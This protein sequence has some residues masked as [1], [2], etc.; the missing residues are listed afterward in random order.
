MACFQLMEG[1]GPTCLYCGWK[2]K[3]K[4]EFPSALPHGVILQQRYLIG[5]VLGQ[6]GFGITYAAYDLQHSTRVAIK[7]YFP[8]D[9]ARRNPNKDVETTSDG[10]Q[11]L[12]QYGLQRFQDEAGSLARFTRHPGMVAVYDFFH[13]HMTAYLVMQYVEGKTWMK[14]IEENGGRMGVDSALGILIPALDALQAVHEVGMLHR[15]ISPDNIMVLPNRQ[16]KLID[17]GA[18][19]YAMKQQNQEF[20]I[21]FKPGFTPEEQY[22]TRGNRGPWSDIYSISATFYKAI[23]GKIPRDAMNR[24]EKDTLTPPSRNGVSLSPSIEHA[25]MK[26]LS[27][28]GENRYQ[29]VR[30]FKEALLQP[31][32]KGYQQG[33]MDN[34]K[35]PAWLWIVG[36]VM[37]LVLIK[38]IT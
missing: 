2:E 33:T 11:E 24:L 32:D 23:T 29:T 14:I 8:I 19:R 18:A 9:I 31:L 26:A 28:K 20:S 4:N 6:G 21:I 5:R 3:I 34:N 12:F 27:V 15:D 16:V 10:Y 22:R 7:E 37:V 1:A 17:F 30:E 25:L 36:F 38:L 13:E 35:T